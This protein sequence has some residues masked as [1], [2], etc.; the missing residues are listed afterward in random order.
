MPAPSPASASPPVP[1]QPFDF[2]WLATTVKR[3]PKAGLVAATTSKVCAVGGRLCTGSR[4]T[5]AGPTGERMP[6]R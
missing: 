3:W 4:S 1:G 6:E 2:E 5:C